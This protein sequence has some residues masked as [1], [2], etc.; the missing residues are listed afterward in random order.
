MDEMIR[1]HQLE[2]VF[3]YL[4]DV[5]VC[6]NSLEYHE[7]NK[8]KFLEAAKEWG[9]SINFE[10]SLP[11]SQSI[12]TLG[13][14][15][16]FGELRPDPDRL[17]GL[18]DLK[19]PET[20]KELERLKGL[21]AYYARWVL[22][23]SEKITVLKDAVFPLSEECLEAIDNLKGSIVNSVRASVDPTLPF[24]VETDASDKAIGAIL[25]QE[26]KPIAFLSRTLSQSEMGQSSVEKEA[27]ACIEAIRKW[28]YYLS[29]HR[30]TLI[31]DQKAVSFIFDPKN[32]GKTKNAKIG[33]WM[34][35]WSSWDWNLM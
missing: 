4:D 21:F 6:G 16:R 7:S 34:G 29:G 1:E 5:T 17:Q 22:N 15:I 35:S 30:F 14:L 31:T 23:F 12:R 2:G 26:D 25:S 18:R 24:L 32:L 9:L 11:L 19:I 33:R 13:Y 3:V 20:P 28:N 27:M 8:N 10:K